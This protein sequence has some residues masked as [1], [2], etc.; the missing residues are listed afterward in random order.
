MRSLLLVAWMVSIASAQAVPQL[1]DPEVPPQPPKVVLDP[2]P[3][4]D[5]P[6]QL[7]P[8]PLYRVPPPRL[9]KQRMWGLFTAGA[10][11]AGVFWLISGTV[12]AQN[13]SYEL[14]VPV[15]GPFVEMRRFSTGSNWIVN[16]PL[17]MTGFIEASG[18][19]MMIVGGTVKHYVELPGGLQIGAAVADGGAGLAL[20]GRF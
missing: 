9:E 20:R 16:I 6:L 17:A 18:V 7:M 5:S 14:L 13:G 15:V 11:M 8:E 12:G 19:V 1:D 3:P 10:S 2:P 4:P